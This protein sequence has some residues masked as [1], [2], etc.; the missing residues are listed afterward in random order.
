MTCCFLYLVSLRFE[1]CLKT[2]VEAA[3]DLMEFLSLASFLFHR[4]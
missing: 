2:T 3:D 4:E 1:T